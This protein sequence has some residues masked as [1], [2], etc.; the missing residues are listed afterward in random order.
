[1]DEEMTEKIR[2]Q[3]QALRSIRD[4]RP[5]LGGWAPGNYLRRCHVCKGG[6]IG[7]KRAMQCADCAYREH[8]SN[9][10]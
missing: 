8:E 9:K 2:W 10:R 6:F 7:D 5:M 3:Q 4:T 1:M